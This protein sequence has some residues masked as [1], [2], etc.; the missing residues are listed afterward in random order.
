MTI[1]VFFVVVSNII[2]VVFVGVGWWGQDVQV[3]TCADG[4][5]GVVQNEGAATDKYGSKEGSLCRM[6][7]GSCTE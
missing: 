3:H 1:G 7:G 4:K 5:E 6:K 2:M